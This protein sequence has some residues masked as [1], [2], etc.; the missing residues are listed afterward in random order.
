LRATAM[1]A[2]GGSSHTLADK[3]AKCWSWNQKQVG[4]PRSSFLPGHRPKSV[5]DL[6]K[7]ATPDKEEISST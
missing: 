3:E 7:T 5:C 6:L 1:G 4:L 2:Q